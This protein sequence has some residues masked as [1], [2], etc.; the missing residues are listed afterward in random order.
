[1][2]RV[3]VIFLLGLAAGVG[4]TIAYRSFAA[5]DQ[6][7][8]AGEGPA[9][10]GNSTAASA[11]RR[12]AVVALGTLEPRDGVVQIGSPLVGLRIKR[13]AVQEGQLVKAGDVLTELDDASLAAEHDLA[14]AQRAEALEKQASSV[15]LAK[16]RVATAQLAVKQATAGRALELAG[17]QARIAVAAAQKEQAAKDADRLEALRKL[18]EPLASQLQVDEQR[19]AAK[20]AGA[21][22]RRQD[23]A[24]AARANAD[25]STAN[26]DRRTARRRAIPRAGRKGGRN[27]RA[28]P[29]RRTGGTPAQAGQDS[30]PQRRH[31]AERRGPSRRNRRSAA[32][33]ADRRF[34]SS[35]LRGRG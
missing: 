24:G 20:A 35:R 32:A 1:M 13:I 3:L 10:G 21:I 12:T 18:P 31:G 25:L 30:R 17:Q 9:S 14:L 26:G 22:R 2:R 33:H 11:T 6:A 34:G 29:P 19:V 28:R 8:P 23:R 27:R 7:P 15:A 16:Q 5:A 4:A